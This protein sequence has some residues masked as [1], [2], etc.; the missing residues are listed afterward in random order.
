MAHFIEQLPQAA[1]EAKPRP[2]NWLHDA[3]AGLPQ[4]WLVVA[5]LDPEGN[6]WGVVVGYQNGEPGTGTILIEPDDALYREGSAKVLAVKELRAMIGRRNRAETFRVET[7]AG[8][9]RER[10]E[11]FCAAAD[12]RVVLSEGWDCADCAVDLGVSADCWNRFSV[13]VVS[14]HLK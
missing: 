11:V 4:D 3:L 10:H 14:L 13:P 8:A 7:M 1:S 9:V 6:G 5:P 12:R 2:T